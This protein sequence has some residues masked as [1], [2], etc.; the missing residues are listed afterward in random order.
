MRSC[1]RHVKRMKKI[2]TIEEVLIQPGA[3][4]SY[5]KLIESGFSKEHLADQIALLLYVPPKMPDLVPSRSDRQTKLLPD[6]IENM[7]DEIQQVN[8][9][10]GLLYEMALEPFAEERRKLR[11][12]AE[13]RLTRHARQG[14]DYCRSLPSMLRTY[15]EYLRY[16]IKKNRKGWSELHDYA[17]WCFQSKIK[18]ATGN[19]HD[20]YVALLLSAAFRAAGDDRAADRFNENQLKALR[21][22]GKRLHPSQKH[23]A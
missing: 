11:N 20:K 15:A 18:N 16:A 9:K 19:Y 12:M 1:P 14:V 8:D 5:D 10:S 4:K 3:R 23:N 7:A 17:I 22:R 13:A 6:R 2:P 21:R